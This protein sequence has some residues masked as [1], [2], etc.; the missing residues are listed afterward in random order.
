MD[1][2]DLKTHGASGTPKVLQAENKGDKGIVFSLDFY[3]GRP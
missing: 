1:S 3:L 2:L